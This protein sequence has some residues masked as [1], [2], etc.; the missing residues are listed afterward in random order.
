MSKKN[1][2]T[3]EVNIKDERNGKVLFSFRE[4]NGNLKEGLKVT[5][6][7]AFYKLGIDIREFFF[8][9]VRGKL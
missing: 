6:E 7:F 8:G 4:G 2:Y 1:P 3:I 5:N 9:K